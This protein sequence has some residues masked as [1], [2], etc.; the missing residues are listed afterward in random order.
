LGRIARKAALARFARTLGTMLENGVPVLQALA[1]V[2]ETMGN[3][4]FAQAIQ[5]TRDRVEDGDSLT[6]PLHASG[7][8]PATVL[9]MID[10]GEQTGAL[11]NMLLK[12]AETYDDEMDNNIASALS[13]LEPVLI[14]FLAIV[15]GSIVI[16]LFLPLVDSFEQGFGGS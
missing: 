12:V 14:L 6:S 16:A 3:A 4:V 1:I 7:I 15:V 5:Q 8:F 11:P 10:V 9:S 2:R 13:L